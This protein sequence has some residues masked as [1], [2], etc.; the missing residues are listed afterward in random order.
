VFDALFGRR[1]PLGGPLVLDPN[2]A[3]PPQDGL[4]VLS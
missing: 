3:Q 2:L 4:K 1:R